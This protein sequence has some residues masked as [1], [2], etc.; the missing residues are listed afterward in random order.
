MRVL[1]VLLYVPVLFSAINGPKFSPQSTNYARGGAKVTAWPNS[2]LSQPKSHNQIV[3]PSHYQVNPYLKVPMLNYER[4]GWSIIIEPYRIYSSWYSY[5][6]SQASSLLNQPLRKWNKLSYYH[7]L[8]SI[9]S[10]VHPV[11]FISNLLLI[12]CLVALCVT[13]NIIVLNGVWYICWLCVKQINPLRIR[14]QNP[15]EE[16]TPYKSTDISIRRLS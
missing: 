11:P 16:K 2:V 1:F 6:A 3:Q 8:D 12:V 7:P 4:A 13:L 14:V 10:F 9:A 5:G 15:I